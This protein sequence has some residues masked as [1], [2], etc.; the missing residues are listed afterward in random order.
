MPETLALVEEALILQ[1]RE[2]PRSAF[3]AGGRAQLKGQEGSHLQ[4]V[5]AHRL[6]GFQ[7]ASP[8]P[9]HSAAATTGTK[10]V[11]G[12]AL[13]QAFTGLSVAIAVQIGVALAQQFLGPAQLPM[14]LQV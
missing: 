8:W 3:H 11:L 2:E 7:M 4:Q 14:L 1:V 5:E 12:F 9:A 13:S 6:G 10:C